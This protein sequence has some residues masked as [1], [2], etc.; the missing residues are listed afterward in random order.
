MRI[1]GTPIVPRLKMSY[2]RE[3]LYQAIAALLMAILCGGA[4]A[5]LQIPQLA[6]LK[7][8]QTAASPDTIQK[9]LEAKKLQLE[10]LKNLPTLGFDNLIANWTFID[11]LIYFGDEYAR[12]QTGYGLS[13]DYFE[14]ILDRDPRFLDIYLFLST[15]LSIYTGTPEES[16][17]LAERGLKFLSPQDPPRSYFIWRYKSFDELLF[18]GDSQAAQK[19]LE[20]AADWASEY[21]DPESK[22]VEEISR[23]MA[24]FL[25]TN[26]DS[27]RVRFAAWMLVFN[28]A[29]DDRTRERAIQGITEIGGQVI[30]TPEGRLQVIPPPEN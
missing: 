18:L 21:S 22:N 20:T 2:S 26:P 19:S 9:E 3:N 28:N 4:I 6:R 1:P 14:V 11:F 25:A 13:S 7:A 16:V 30:T 5:S 10:L 8:S 17:A 23:R 24:S 12:N 15:T 29:R 27:K